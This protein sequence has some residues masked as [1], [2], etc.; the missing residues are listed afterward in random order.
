MIRLMLTVAALAAVGSAVVGNSKGDPKPI[1]L[2]ADASIFRLAWAPGGKKIAVVGVG[3]D[4]KQKGIQSTLGF[5]DAEKGE[6]RRSV[7]L[8]SMT[9]VESIAFSPD[10]KTLAIATTGRAGKAVY[11]V[12]LIDP[13]TG[14][15]RK[16]IPLQGT[17]RSAVFS[18]DGKMLA[19]GG[20]DLPKSLTGPF[21]RTVQL[22]DVNKERTIREFRQELRVDDIGK[23]GQLDGL[24]DLRF[25]PDGKILA[26][27]DVDFRVRLIDVRTGGV[28]QTLQ[29]HTEVILALAFSPDGK[30]LASAGFDRTVRI[31][32]TRD[33]KE[34]RT[35][36]RNK[37]QV[38]TL[39]FSPDGKLL[40]TGGMLVAD[41]ARSGEVILWDAHSWQ[42][43][44]VLPG[45]K[46][47]LETPA[48]SP[49]NKVLAVGVGTEE[50]AGAI[51]LW[52]SGDLLQE[53]Q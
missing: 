21:V 42:P 31:W 41:G 9:T 44:R 30:A 46:G 37:G 36:E 22:W 24:R 6:I 2:K 1:I 15:T 13:E 16:T 38:W 47:S 14:A 3:Y 19:I 34:I 48:F 33:G 5:W 28:Q 23:S 10:G 27:A 26:A 4:R 12:R 45:D 25:S 20:Q 51:Q 39:A 50:G 40:A 7:G 18:P 53:R 43:R 8:E 35:L 11:A 49:D 32:D 29:G 52:Q 17:V